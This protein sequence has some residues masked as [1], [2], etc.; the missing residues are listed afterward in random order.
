[1]QRYQSEREREREREKSGTLYECILM[2]LSISNLF[3]ELLYQVLSIFSL[4]FF[5]SSV[6]I[7]MEEHLLKSAKMLRL[8]SGQLASQVHFSFLFLISLST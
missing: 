5:F 6:L 2:Q 4:F 3:L 1:M 8:T 7:D